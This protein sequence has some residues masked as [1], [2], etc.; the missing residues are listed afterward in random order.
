MSDGMTFIVGI[1]VGLVA[2]VILTTLVYWAFRR[3]EQN[4]EIKRLNGDIKS[5][6]S[7]LSLALNAQ[8]VSQGRIRD[9]SDHN[10]DQHEILGRIITYMRSQ[11]PR[12]GDRDYSGMLSDVE[13]VYNRGNAHDR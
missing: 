7:R 5:L 10:Q 8:G 3:M 11:P 12:I 1:F 9:L 2:G 4:E 6:G 13:K